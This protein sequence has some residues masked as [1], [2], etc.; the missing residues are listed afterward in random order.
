[1]ILDEVSD[2]T[3]PHPKAKHSGKNKYGPGANDESVSWNII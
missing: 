1:M 2:P 3:T